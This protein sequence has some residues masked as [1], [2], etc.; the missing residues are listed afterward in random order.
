MLSGTG[1]SPPS[2][3]DV[4]GAALRWPALAWAPLHVSLFLALYALSF[5]LA[6]AGVRPTFKALL[7]PALVLEVVLPALVGFTVALSF[8]LHGRSFRIVAPLA[9]G[10]VTIAMAIDRQICRAL[11]FHINSLVVRVL[12]QP[13]ALAETGIPAW[14][15]VA[16]LAAAARWLTGEG[17]GRSAF[18]DGD[19]RFAARAPDILCSF[20]RPR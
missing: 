15:V 7:W 19:A 1:T 10:L 3:L 5:G 13:G 9:A 18:L 6:I 4:P 12:L 16:A 14:D 8:S 17:W 2:G 11:G 20:V